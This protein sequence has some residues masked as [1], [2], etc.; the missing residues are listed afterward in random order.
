MLQKRL[1]NL[2]GDIVKEE[3]E[4][5]GARDNIVAGVQ[6]GKDVGQV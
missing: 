5:A 1:H 4:L 2:E 3:Q 6:A